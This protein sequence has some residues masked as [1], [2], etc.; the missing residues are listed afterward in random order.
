MFLS[1]QVQFNVHD[2]NKDVLEITV[3]DQDIF[4]PNGRLYLEYGVLY[5]EFLTLVF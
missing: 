2:L 5:L 4:S 1:V 3:F